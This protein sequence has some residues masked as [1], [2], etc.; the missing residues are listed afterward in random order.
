MLSFITNQNRT[1][2]SLLD[3]YSNFISLIQLFISKAHVEVTRI[4]KARIFSF[5]DKEMY[6]RGI[7]YTYE[8]T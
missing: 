7:F 3:Y 5:Q 4:A 1:A 6:F 8:G 2:P